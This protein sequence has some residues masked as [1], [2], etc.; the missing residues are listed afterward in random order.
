LYVEV[1]GAYSYHNNVA[2]TIAHEENAK[3]VYDLIHFSTRI[4]VSDPVILIRVFVVSYCFK[5][6]E[7]DDRPVIR[8]TKPIAFQLWRCNSM[9]S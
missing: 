8:S 1:G 2:A 4:A 7:K 3:A 6:K 5:R 9:H